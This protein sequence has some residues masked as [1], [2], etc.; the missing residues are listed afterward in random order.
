MSLG[1]KK[2][3]PTADGTGAPGLASA[4]TSKGATDAWFA[5]APSASGRTRAHASLGDRPTGKQTATLRS[6][7]EAEFERL[8]AGKYR[9]LNEIARGGMGVVHRALHVDLNQIVALKVLLAGTA[10]TTKARQ[11]FMFEAQAAARLKHPHILPVFDIG[12]D[13]EE[14]YFT[15]AFV[16]GKDLKERRK[17]F[18]REKLLDIMIKVTDAVS[19]AHQRGIIH[20]DLKPANVMLTADDQ[21]LVMDFG[22]AK[23][24]EATGKDEDL[25][26][27]ELAQTKAGTV[28]GTPFYMSPEQAS[29]ETDEIDVRTDVYTLGVILYQLWTGQ[30][31]FTAEQTPQLIMEILTKDPVRPRQV[32]PTISPDLEAIILK[33]MEKSAAARYQTAAALKEDL[34]RLRDGL[35]VSAQRATVAY[36]LKK[37]L[38]RNRAPVGVAGALLA[39]ALSSAGWL[40]YQERARALAAV[41]RATDDH[42]ALERERQEVATAVAALLAGEG[43]LAGRRTTAARLIADLDAEEGLLRRLERARGPLEA[44]VGAL[45]AAAALAASFEA[46]R[47]GAADALA[48]LRD[49][50]KVHRELDAADRGLEDARALQAAALECLARAGVAAVSSWTDLD[51]AVAGGRA[52]LAE[53]VEGEGAVDLPA[54]CAAARDAL[55]AHG[56]ALRGALFAALRLAPPVGPEPALAQAGVETIGA[57]ER[58]VTAAEQRLRAARLADRLLRAADRLVELLRAEPLPGRDAVRSKRLEGA[59]L[60]RA[61]VQRAAEADPTAPG[62]AE[63]RQA[64]RFVHAWML[65]GVKA[66]QVFDVEVRA[67]DEYAPADLEA[68]VAERKRNWDQTQGLRRR[69]ERAGVLQIEIRSGRVEVRGVAEDV[70]QTELQTYTRQVDLLERTA[71]HA[72]LN[73]ELDALRLERLA[74][75]RARIAEIQAL[76]AARAEEAAPAAEPSVDDGR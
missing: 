58:E 12:A 19:F 67:A 31:P 39:V 45:P 46:S 41:A 16:Q 6:A 5:P 60:A 17:E 64:A 21:P 4:A 33:A 22:L 62:L 35:P 69:I 66:Y 24:I 8:Y 51:A 73:D 10:A 75:M 56:Q 53:V 68:L 37:W 32:D 30:L 3:K 27:S 76:L 57:L 20:R 50:A 13:G 49:L 25:L 15:M 7:R 59:V 1:K 54:E 26:D 71:G 74:A 48:S 11:R 43:D 61:F 9:L 34:E 65:L 42:A 72:Y 38:R 14:L 44:H 28:L 2:K 29:G 36:R 63:A 23:E 55:Q 18:D 40:A 52:L 47:G 70:L